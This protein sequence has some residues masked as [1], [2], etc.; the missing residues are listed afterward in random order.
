VNDWKLEPELQSVRRITL[1][2]LLDVPIPFPVALDAVAAEM[3]AKRPLDVF[4]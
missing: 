4:P 2:R 1:L 3:V